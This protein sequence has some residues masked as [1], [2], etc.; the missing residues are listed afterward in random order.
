MLRGGYQAHPK[1]DVKRVF[2]FCHN[3][4]LYVPYLNRV[5]NSC[6][7]VLKGYDF[8]KILRTIFRVVFH[9]KFV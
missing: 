5:S 3:R 9:A 6:K 2:F 4:A 8:L 1:I 7:I